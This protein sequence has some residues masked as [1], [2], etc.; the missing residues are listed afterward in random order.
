MSSF[1][2]SMKSGNSSGNT[3]TFNFDAFANAPEPSLG[4][5]AAPPVFEP[6]DS[7]TTVDHMASMLQQAMSVGT[8]S[9]DTADKVAAAFKALASNASKESAPEPTLAPGWN[10]APEYT[11]LT[12]PGWT[13]KIDEFIGLV[14]AMANK[15]V[16]DQIKQAQAAAASGSGSKRKGQERRSADPLAII[17][18][19]QRQDI[20]RRFKEIVGFIRSATDITLVGTAIVSLAKTI[21]R[22]RAVTGGGRM[23]KNGKG[24]RA[25][26]YLMFTLFYEEFADLAI[27]MVPLFIEYGYFGDIAALMGYYYPKISTT[28]YR[29]IFDVLVDQYVMALTGD[30]RIITDGRDLSELSLAKIGK[31]ITGLN[32]KVKSLVDSGMSPEQIKSQFPKM[33]GFT[34]A[35]HWMKREGKHNSEWR[36]HVTLRFFYSGMTFAEAK[37]RANHNWCQMIFRKFISAITTLSGTA[38]TFM[39]AGNWNFDPRKLSSG[40]AYKHRLAYLNEKLGESCPYD[41]TE[42][43]NRHPYDAARVAMRKQMLAAAE[44]GEIKGTTTDTMKMADSIWKHIPGVPYGSSEGNWK[45]MSCRITASAGERKTVNAQFLDCI[46]SLRE[47]ISDADASAFA[48]WEANG[49]KPEEKPISGFNIANVVD[50]SGSMGGIMQYAI[51]NGIAAAHLSTLGKWVI[52]FETKPRI[53]D[54]EGCTDI[55]DM[56]L[57][58]KCAPWGGST[59]LTAAHQLLIRQ[60]Q[61]VRK[62][63]PE[64]DG[65]VINIVHTDGQMNPSFAGYGSGNYSS[66][67]SETQWAPYVKTLEAMYKKAH[68]PMAMTAWWNY[69]SRTKGFTAHGHTQGV[70]FVEGLTPGLLYEVVCSGTTFTTKPD[71]TVVAETSPI[72]SF[73]SG[74]ALPGYDLVADTLYATASGVFSDTKVVDSVK[75]FWSNY[76]PPPEPEK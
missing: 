10:G 33:N 57:K 36:Y 75:D 41:M 42:T 48:K 65:H 18:H 69:N 16:M 66:A 19:S 1:P 55:Y 22:E 12:V 54:F 23:A 7:T 26:S 72:E 27:A 68:L 13:S 8:L 34:N 71:G 38:E 74:L 56:F 58:V 15:S 3:D 31:G 6:V 14:L 4:G 2:A 28:K 44:S 43:G 70:K 73:L 30:L 17:P 67:F 47:K 61:T 24:H 25:L 76:A 37:L 45:S 20:T 35:A 52:T 53:I 60:I 64:F 5:A 32:T 29:R 9:G 39:A 63:V 59:N 51:M 40:K 62:A 46:K 11:T 50:V 49:S 21:F